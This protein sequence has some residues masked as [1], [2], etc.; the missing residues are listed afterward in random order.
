M[1]SLPFA[2][3]VEIEAEVEILNEVSVNS[4]NGARAV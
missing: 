4:Y 2:I 1:A 3:P